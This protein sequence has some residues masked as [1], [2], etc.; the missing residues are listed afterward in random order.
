[1]I[2]SESN[3]ADL[4]RLKARA[5]RLADPQGAAEAELADA[6]RNGIAWARVPHG[7]GH[8]HIF[9][10]LPQYRGWPQGTFQLLYRTA[11]FDGQ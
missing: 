5:R 8:I 9:G 1:V 7:R 11:F 3:L 2:S 10:F 6:V 4:D